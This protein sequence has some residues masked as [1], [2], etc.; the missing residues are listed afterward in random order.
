MPPFGN[1][2]TFVTLVTQEI[3]K[4]PSIHSTGFVLC[5]GSDKL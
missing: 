1:L 5:L 2:V 3:Q 4:S